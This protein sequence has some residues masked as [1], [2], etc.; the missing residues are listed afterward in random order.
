MQVNR[1]QF[2]L[3]V[4]LIAA[5]VLAGLTGCKTHER[6]M[7][8]RMDDRQVARSVSKS[9][10]KEPVYKYPDVKVQSFNGVVELS[11]FVDTEDQ[12][13]RAAEIAQQ[14][15]SVRE[16]VNGLTLKPQA[17]LPPAGSPTGQRYGTA[18]QSPSS[19]TTIRQP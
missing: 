8:Q 1:K 10:K 18:P 19:S 4:W 2:I 7:G 13:R 14:V 12:K 17:T 3:A 11:G 16:V 15:P 6:T 9:L 5:V